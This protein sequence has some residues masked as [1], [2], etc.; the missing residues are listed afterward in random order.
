ML[1]TIDI[2]NTEVTLGLFEAKRIVRSYRVSSETRRTADEAALLL[3]QI[4]PEL[5]GTNGAAEPAKKA[6]GSRRATAKEHDCVIAAFA[7]VS[8]NAAMGGNGKVLERAHLGVGATML[9]GR[10]V[11]ADAVVGGG[12]LVARDIAPSIA[13]KGVPA[14]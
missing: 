1:L 3:R 2:G 5:A 6:K 7:H 9:P 10:T 13:V 12:A 8:P 4:A 14:R 11:G